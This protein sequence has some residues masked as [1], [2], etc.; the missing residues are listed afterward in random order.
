MTVPVFSSPMSLLMMENCGARLPDPVYSVG[1]FIQVTL[2]SAASFKGFNASYE[3]IDKEQGK[4][5]SMTLFH[6]M[7]PSAELITFIGVIVKPILSTFSNS[8]TD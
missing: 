6:I 2:R 1:N 4:Q 3:A 5:Y 8:L 7:H